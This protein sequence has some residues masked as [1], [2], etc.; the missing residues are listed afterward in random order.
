MAWI[1]VYTYTWR[2]DGKDAKDKTSF[3]M[4]R[5]NNIFH[6]IHLNVQVDDMGDCGAENC[7]KVGQTV[8]N[9]G[10]GA[11][12]PRVFDE[13]KCELAATPGI[14]KPLE[15]DWKQMVMTKEPRR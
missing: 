15:E 4:F 9:V 1:K 11:W 2:R 7:G 8:D 3:F 12:R 10:R 13:A 6:V 14:K 5:M